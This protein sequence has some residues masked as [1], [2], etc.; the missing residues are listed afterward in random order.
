MEF[1]HWR[2]DND[3]LYIELIG[4]IDTT[5]AL[6]VEQEI[7]AVRGEHAGQRIVLDAEKLDYISSAGL[8]VILRLRKL[9]KTLSL[10]NASLAVYEVLEMTGFT[11]MLPVK[12]AYRRLS[13]EGCEMIGRGAA[14][15]VYR[16]DAETIVKVY[17]NADALDEIQRERELS[18]KTFVLGI[19]TAIPYD[20]VR[21]GD[22]YGTVAELLEAKSIS[23]LI[24]ANPEDLETPARYFVDMAKN[25]HATHLEKGELPDMK[26]LALNWV[27]FLK[28]HLPA[29]QWEKLHKLVSEVPERDTMMHGDYHTNNIMVRNGET[30]LIDMDTLCMGHPIFEL[31][32]MFNAFVGFSEVNPEPAEKSFLGFSFETACKFWRLS[33]AMYLGTE[34]EE[35]IRSVEE[36][37]MIVGYT[38]MLRRTLRRN[39][40]DGPER[41][42]RC[43]EMLAILLE[44]VDT[45]DF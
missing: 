28:P 14:G 32:S 5:N 37:T 11:D 9:E 1:I 38:R 42:A 40:V 36:K 45:L 6:A 8:R 25:I 33:L 24:R 4:K 41:I 13:I 31:G 34:N 35:V 30:L 22:G 2:A 26:A 27:D 44:K 10:I 7:M 15:A 3:V 16:Y 19:N 17:H 39:L 18:K 21:V 23:K 29:D 43:K 12:K 20:V